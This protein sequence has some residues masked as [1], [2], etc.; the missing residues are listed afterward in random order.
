M[1]KD[2]EKKKERTVTPAAYFGRKNNEKLTTD[3]LRKEAFKQYCEHMAA[4]KSKRSWY[5]DHPTINLTYKSIDN[6]IKDYPEIFDEAALEVAKTKGYGFWEKVVGDSALGKNTKAN[7]ATLQMLMRNRFGWD[8]RYENESDESASFSEAF[9]SLMNQISSLQASVTINSSNSAS[10]EASE[11][12]RILGTV[13]SSSMM[14]EEIQ[15]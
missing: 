9:S 4:G 14:S 1:S 12:A 15:I 8:R 10:I 7:T 5:F 6:Y 13:K 11:R 2:L 3:K